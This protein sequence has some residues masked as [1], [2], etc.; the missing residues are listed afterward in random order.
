MAREMRHPL[1]GNTYGIDDDGLVRVVKGS[2]EYGRF[3]W[4][5]R[6]V[7]GPVRHADP[8]LC[9]WIGG[10]KLPEGADSLMAMLT[11]PAETTT[12]QPA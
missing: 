1:S 7:E 2:G 4:D 11:S 8:Q 3:Q 9:L 6:W 5:G 12:G 10:P